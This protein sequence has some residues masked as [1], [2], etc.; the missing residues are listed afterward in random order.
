MLDAL[1]SV[2][3]CNALYQALF[4]RVLQACNRLSL[5]CFYCEIS[6]CLLWS[7]FKNRFEN[8]S[9][10]VFFWH[11]GEW[12]LCLCIFSLTNCGLMTPYSAME[13][14]QLWFRQWLGA[15]QQAIAWTKADQ[16]P[17]LTHHRRG[18][19]VYTRRQFHMDISNRYV[20]A[21]LG[22]SCNISRINI[23]R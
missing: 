19:V 6:F 7:Y 15:M 16:V 1:L 9:C 12:L 20:L 4:T 11:G 2:C 18:P 13:P 17:I 10:Y 21:T 3:W 23:E 14:G 22:C 8:D 5:L